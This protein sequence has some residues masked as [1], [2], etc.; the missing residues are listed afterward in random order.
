MLAKK[1]ADRPAS[2]RDVVQHI[3]AIKFL[4]RAGA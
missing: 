1:P 4:N 2:M 3:G